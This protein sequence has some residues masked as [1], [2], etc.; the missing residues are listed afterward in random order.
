MHTLRED[1]LEVALYA[2]WESA[3][4]AVRDVA[5]GTACFAGLRD[6]LAAIRREA[7]AAL[8]LDEEGAQEPAA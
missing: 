8:G 4:G 3:D 1:R 7:G 6:A 2:V 5:D